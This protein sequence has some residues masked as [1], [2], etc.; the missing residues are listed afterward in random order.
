MRGAEPPRDCQGE[1]EAQARISLSGGGHG[2]R[3]PH[4]AEGAHSS[5][6]SNSLGSRN[7]LWGRPVFGVPECSF[8]SPWRSPEQFGSV[9]FASKSGLRA[10]E[11]GWGPLAERGEGA[12]GSRC[13]R[14]GKFLW[15]T[16]AQTSGLH[17]LSDKDPHQ[18]PVL[19]TPQ[20]TS[21]RAEWKS[22]TLSSRLGATGV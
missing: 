22:R 6:H 15:P 18:L 14:A 2:R 17:L 3:C 16:T 8:V 12:L 10:G 19:P 5:P 11:S 13:L 21:C 4:P 1:I 9:L 20:P 7:Q